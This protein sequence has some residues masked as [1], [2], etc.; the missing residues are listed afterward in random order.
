MK[1]AVHEH[2]ILPHI[3][4]I[5]G[6][7]ISFEPTAEVPEEFGKLMVKNQPK[8]YFEV[9]DGETVDISKYRY[10]DFYQ[11]KSFSQIFNLL[12]PQSKSEFIALVKQRHKEETTPKVEESP[13]SFEE[14]TLA[15]LK[16]YAGENN[17][18]IPY[19]VTKKNDILALILDA[20]K[21]KE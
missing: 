4:N 15:E 14:F 10:K 5:K 6:K 11:D 8:V 7:D 18:E 2:I 12:T 1:I 21:P 9:K 20:Q 19:N 17:I 16:A 3:L 13:K